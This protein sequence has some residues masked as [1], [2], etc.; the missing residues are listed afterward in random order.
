MQVNYGG[1]ELSLIDYPGYPAVVIFLRGCSLNCP[2]CHNAGLKTGK[3]MIELAE[4]YQRIPWQ[5][6][7]AVVISGGEPLEQ[8]EVCKDI[9]RQAH[10]MKKVVAIQTSGCYPDRMKD[11]YPN[12]WYVDTKPE[13]DYSHYVFLA[14]RFTACREN[15][16]EGIKYVRIYDRRADLH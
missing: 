13:L 3:V 11:L 10:G 9:I 6:I 12:R 5:F 16:R 14:A 15:V 1:M 2:L 8:P 7:D 4:I